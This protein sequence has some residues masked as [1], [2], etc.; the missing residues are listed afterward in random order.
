MK[1]EVLGTGCPK[2]KQLEQAVKEVIKELK[3][4]TEVNKVTDIEQI[5]EYDVMNM[6]ALVVNGKIVVSGRLPSKDEIKSW[7]K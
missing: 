1:I 7:L 6:P 3:I 2:C 5:I 4:K